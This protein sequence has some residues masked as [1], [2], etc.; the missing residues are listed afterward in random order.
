MTS[1]RTLL[2]A[3]SLSQVNCAPIVYELDDEATTADPPASTDPPT[4][5]PET[6]DPSMSCFDGAWNEGESD[7][8][9]GGPCPPCGPGQHCTQPDDCADGMCRDGVCGPL[10]C[11]GTGECPAPGPC[12]RWDCDPRT[13]CT[14]TPDAEGEP[15]DAAD[16]CVLAGQCVQGECSGPTRDCSGFAGPCRASACNPA[17]GNCEIEAIAE[18]QPCDDGLACTFGEQCVQGECSGKTPQPLLTTDFSAPDGWFMDPL[19]KI[20]PAQPSKCAE[21][22]DDPPQDHSPGPDEQLAGAVIGGCLPNIGFPLSCLTSPPIDVKDPP[23]GL[24]LRYWSVLNT[25]GAPME[26]RIDVFDAKSQAWNP[27][28]KFPEFTAEPEWTEH[29]LDLGPFIGPGLRVRFCHLAP[30][31]IPQVGGWSLDDLSIGPP[32]CE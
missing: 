23:G 11:Q 5:G 24:W 17:T 26:S 28:A 3:W 8:D 30:G 12:L 27:L 31:P 29:V 21:K 10:D 1:L 20:G 6:M 4:T 15:C 32:I 13:G 14:P 25:A 7:L 22:G 18:G 2:I 16:L 19:W 9:C